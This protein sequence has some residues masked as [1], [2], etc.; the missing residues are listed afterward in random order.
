ML[1]SLI[2]R[3]DYWRAKADAEYRQYDLDRAAEPQDGRGWARGF[4]ASWDRYQA[5][6]REAEDCFMP[7]E[8]LSR[9][10][11]EWRDGGINDPRWRTISKW[12]P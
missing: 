3:V 6:A 7:F 12:L 11:W 2:R 4:P 8:R 1:I 9:R 5:A 10:R